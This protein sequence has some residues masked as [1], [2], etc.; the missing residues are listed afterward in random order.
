MMP[1]TTRNRITA[2]F[3]LVEMII[4]IVISGI[5]AVIL[6]TIIRGPIQGVDNQIRRAELVDMAESALRRM[7]RDVRAA[8]PNSVRITSNAAGSGDVTCPNG[9]HTI[10]YLEIL[11]TVDGGRYRVGP[12]GAAAN[13]FQFG[14]PDTDFD[15]IGTLPNFGNYTVNTSSLVVNNQTTT[16]TQYNAYFGDNRTLLTSPGTTA[17][18]ISMVSKNFAAT[19][20]STRQR[21]L[22]VDTPI[23]YRCDTT[24]GRLERYQNYAI[25]AAQPTPPAGTPARV[26]NL[27]AGC[28]FAYQSGASA[29][30]GL[31]TMELTVRDDTISSDRVRLLH[32]VHVYNIP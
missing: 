12:P 8:L 16:G 14:V 6:A 4:V 22:I 21:F 9:A 24:T 23:T 15:V 13:I 28:R 3:T 26:G 1:R 27:I 19:L 31:V 20:A 5:I 30:A 17:S 18:H 29:T 11:H 32:Q 2:G 7:T 25:A 10:C